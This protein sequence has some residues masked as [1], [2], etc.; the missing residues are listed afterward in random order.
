[1]SNTYYKYNRTY[2]LEWSPGLQNDDRRQINYEEFKKYG[3]IVATIKMDG[4][5]SNLYPDYTHAR[6][7]NSNNHPSRDYVK[8]IWG[9]IKYRIPDGWRICGENIYA[10]HS[11]YY[12][13]LESY[14]QAFS[15]WDENNMCLDYDTTLDLC[16]EFGIVHVK[17]IYRGKYDEDILKSLIDLPEMEGQEGYVIRTCGS[18]HYDDFNDNVA[19]Y[20]RKN[21]VQTSNHW[22]NEKIIPNKLA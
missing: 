14:F 21:H 19:K 17:E 6:S 15:I 18:F 22:L 10:K 20:V 12:D 9:N 7:I 16:K 4:E 8:G 3:D 2:H 11:I 5:N 13:N 1:M